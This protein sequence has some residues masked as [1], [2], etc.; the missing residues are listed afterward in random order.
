MQHHSACAALVGQRLSGIKN[1]CKSWVWGGSNSNKISRLGPV[2]LF[3]G[4]TL[5][6]LTCKLQFIRSNNRTPLAH[7]VTEPASWRESDVCTMETSVAMAR[8]KT[9]GCWLGRFC[10]SKTLS[11]VEQAMH[12][13][14]FG[15]LAARHNLMEIV[16]ACRK[17]ANVG[18]VDR[19]NNCHG[20]R[21][22]L[23][24]GRSCWLTRRMPSCRE[25]HFPLTRRSIK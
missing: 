18:I 10:R 15:T 3:C 25:R 4:C 8:C 17:E 21:W 2:I 16:E 11:T 13:A 24:L 19:I 9:L 1:P 20:R 12:P 22:L 14:E 7:V 5:P 6:P 23:L